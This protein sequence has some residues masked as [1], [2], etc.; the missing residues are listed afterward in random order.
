MIDILIDSKIDDFLSYSFNPDDGR[1]SFVICFKKKIAVKKNNDIFI[2]INNIGA[3]AKTFNIADCSTD[4][5]DFSVKSDLLN[6]LTYNLPSLLS[7]DLDE[8]NSSFH[9]RAEDNQYLLFWVGFFNIFENEIRDV[10]IKIFVNKNQS[11]I[12]EKLNYFA[13]DI[14]ISH[15]SFKK[16]NDNL[17]YGVMNIKKL[18]YTKALKEYLELF[19]SKSIFK[20]SINIDDTLLTIVTEMPTWNENIANKSN[21]YISDFYIY[22][23]IGGKWIKRKVTRYFPYKFSNGNICV[24]DSSFTKINISEEGMSLPSDDIINEALFCEND[25]RFFNDNSFDILALVVNG[26]FSKSNNIDSFIPIVEYNLS[27]YKYIEDFY[28]SY[29]V[30]GKVENAVVYSH[31]KFKVSVILTD[32]NN[33]IKTYELS[34]IDFLNRVASVFQGENISVLDN[35]IENRVK[36]IY[37]KNTVANTINEIMDMM[38]SNVNFYCKVRIYLK[39]IET[40]DLYIDGANEYKNLYMLANY[41]RGIKIE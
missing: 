37:F 23:Y 5:V 1:K 31:L 11:N 33:E 13:D 34:S 10:D 19:A 7:V 25:L 29:T 27:E 24:Y 32:G 36:I 12:I 4:T 17:T 6:E 41:V 14:V 22:S 15:E 38:K 18:F 8:G 2:K 39:K 21:I 3:T 30:G 40:E 26:D 35:Y 9:F 16:I 20:K 28:F